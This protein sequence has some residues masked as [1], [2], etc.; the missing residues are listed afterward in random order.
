MIKIPKIYLYRG[1]GSAFAMGGLLSHMSVETFMYKEAIGEKTDTMTVTLNVSEKYYS[2]MAGIEKGTKILFS[3]GYIH[4]QSKTVSLLITDIR[5]TY[6]SSGYLITITAKPLADTLPESIDPDTIIDGK[7]AGI[8]LITRV[9]YRE[10]HTTSLPPPPTPQQKRAAG[11]LGV[12]IQAHQSPLGLNKSLAQSTAGRKPINQAEATALHWG[13]ANTD[14]TAGLKNSVYKLEGTKLVGVQDIN[15]QKPSPEGKSLEGGGT[16][17]TTHGNSMIV[18]SNQAS[19]VSIAT[20]SLA[21]HSNII[22]AIFQ[23]KEIPDVVAGIIAGTID[24]STKQ[25]VTYE[26]LTRAGYTRTTPQ[27]TES[28]RY[29]VFWESNKTDE[30]YQQTHQGN[31]TSRVHKLS[32]KDKKSYIAM[33]EVNNSKAVDERLRKESKSTYSFTNSMG[34]TVVNPAAT[35]TDETFDLASQVPNQWDR[36]SNPMVVEHTTPSYLEVHREDVDPAQ[37]IAAAIED[38][39]IENALMA[40][41]DNKNFHRNS[42]IIT[43]EG[44][45]TIS[46]GDSIQIS[47]FAPAYSGVYSVKVVSHSINSSGYTTQITGNLIPKDYDTKIEEIRK[48]WGDNIEE[49]TKQVIQKTLDGLTKDI[50]AMNEVTSKGGVVQNTQTIDGVSTNN[51]VLSNVYVEVVEVVLGESDA[52]NN[53][54]LVKE[55]DKTILKTKDAEISGGT[56]HS[57]SGNAYH[58]N[59]DLDH[60]VVHNVN[61]GKHTNVDPG[62]NTDFPALEGS[63]PSVQSTINETRAA[64]NTP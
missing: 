1:D 11:A 2:S 63:K 14:F 5:A 49:K 21:P 31:N 23:S 34:K 25:E 38:I 42:C 12:Y 33:K 32:D 61:E 46:E 57:Y 29:L 30:I 52:V 35:F 20:H 6:G 41:L 54:A 45:P 39:N 4:W 44:K 18:S 8:R 26:T 60:T 27:A 22:T 13:N 53:W 37:Q 56:N 48:N 19:Q 51:Q 16:S 36:Q 40:A 15:A 59:G 3:Y 64:N 50:D 47:G 58:N 9:S 62:T 55:G 24:P 7:L 17:V 43:I 28:D 10:E